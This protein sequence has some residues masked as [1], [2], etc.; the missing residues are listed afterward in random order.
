MH[1]PGHTLGSSGILLNNGD[2]LIAF[3]GDLVNNERETGKPYFQ[4]LFAE[5]WVMVAAIDGHILNFKKVIPK[6]WVHMVFVQIF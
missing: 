2:T 3:T 1:L 6:F 5:S 4:D